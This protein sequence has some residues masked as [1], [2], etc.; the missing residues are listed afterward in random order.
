MMFLLTTLNKNTISQETTASDSKSAPY[1][2]S[3]L[4]PRWQT[5]QRVYSGCALWLY[6]VAVQRV[7][8]GCARQ[9]VQWLC[10]VVVLSDSSGGAS[11]SA[12]PP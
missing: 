3:R 5:V 4:H 12:P 6:S 7:C 8:N 2:L 10:S 1:S 11:S 9:A